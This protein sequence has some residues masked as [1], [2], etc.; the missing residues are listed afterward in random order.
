MDI[1]L[2]EARLAARLRV[3]DMADRVELLDRLALL[4]I[5]GEREDLAFRV[6]ELEDWHR[7][8][9]QLMLQASEEM[10][11]A[12]LI[13]R[14]QRARVAELEAERSGMGTTEWGRRDRFTEVV[15]AQKSE[16]NARE[17]V[18]YGGGELVSRTAPGPWRVAT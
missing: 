12:A 6:A 13:I 17:S 4:E 8:R 3:K 16:A 18:R 2:S 1:D 14:E 11:K 7:E 15:Y 10:N 9:D 5:L